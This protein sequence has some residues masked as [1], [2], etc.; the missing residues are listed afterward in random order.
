MPDLDCVPVCVC[1]DQQRVDR[2]DG[3]P[4]HQI[5]GGDLAE[6]FHPQVDN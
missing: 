6:V 4:Q 1:E 5:F 3:W 2:E